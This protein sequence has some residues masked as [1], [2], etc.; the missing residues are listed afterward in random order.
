M[1][2]EIEALGPLDLGEDGQARPKSS[3][4]LLPNRPRK[5]G[6]QVMPEGPQAEQ[7]KV[8]LEAL[9]KAQQAVEELAEKITTPEPEAQAGVEG[10][11]ASATP[12][13][14]ME[15]DP[16]GGTADVRP[17]FSDKEL[18]ELAGKLQAAVGAEA[19]AD[20]DEAKK[21]LAETLRDFQACKKRKSG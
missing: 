21:R 14:R 5:V 15:T 12:D 18:D 19:G 9:A 3:A 2:Q 6:L 8:Q 13:D 11:Q 7:W 1:E 17:G 20:S 10:G 4:P 16:E